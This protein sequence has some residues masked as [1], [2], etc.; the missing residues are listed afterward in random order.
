MNRCFNYTDLLHY[1][2]K[3]EMSESDILNWLS[4]MMNAF[5]E[6]SKITC[7]SGC[8]YHECGYYVAIANI[9]R[10]IKSQKKNKK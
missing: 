3:F 8:W 5:C 4:E 7:G 6:S 2:E 9:V 1:G 10:I